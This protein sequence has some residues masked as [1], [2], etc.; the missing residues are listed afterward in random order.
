MGCVDT[1]L[2]YVYWTF[3][4]TTECASKTGSD[5]DKQPPVCLTELQFPVPIFVPVVLPDPWDSSSGSDSIM[6]ALLVSMRFDLNKSFERNEIT[7]N[8]CKSLGSYLCH[9]TCVY[10]CSDSTVTERVFNSQVTPSV[11]AETDQQEWGVRSAN[12]GPLC[13]YT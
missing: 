1:F 11:C 13:V 9:V 12:T 5:W 2:L 4:L 8:E 10:S 6:L 7:N 3:D